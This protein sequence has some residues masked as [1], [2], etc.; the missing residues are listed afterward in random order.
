MN[1][2]IERERE[3]YEGGSRVPS[4]LVEDPAMASRSR[5]TTARWQYCSRGAV[6]TAS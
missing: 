3:R 6:A 2:E 4:S 5:S 1:R